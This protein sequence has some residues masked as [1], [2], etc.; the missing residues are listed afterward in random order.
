MQVGRYC[1]K[2]VAKD[3]TQKVGLEYN[4]TFS[5]VVRH[6]T[7]HF[8]FA[9]SVHLSL[10][11]NHLDVTTAFYNGYLKE[12]IYMY[13]PEGFSFQNTENK[14]L[15]MR[16][17]VYRL[18]QFAFAWYQRVDKT[19]CDLGYENGNL[20]PYLFI[21]NHINHDK[22]VVTLYVYDFLIFSN[23]KRETENLKVVLLNI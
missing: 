20:E 5:P 18:K 9:F 13:L 8:L 14:I 21:K 15:K 23:N 22:R 2:L 10:N 12:N 11:I 1:A 17:A 4:E 7:L 6:S 19:L 16:K 3:F